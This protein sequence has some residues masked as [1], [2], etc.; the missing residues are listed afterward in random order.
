VAGSQKDVDEFKKQLWFYF[1]I[2]A[3]GAVKKHLGVYY[4]R[5]QD[6]LGKYIEAN[7]LDF[8]KEMLSDFTELTGRMPK[9]AATP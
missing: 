1:T 4:E 9:I 7:M 8:V 6:S 3:L 2:K 5:G